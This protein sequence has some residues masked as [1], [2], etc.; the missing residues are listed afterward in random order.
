MGFNKWDTWF[1]NSFPYVFEEFYFFV[2][3]ILEEK[4]TIILLLK[5]LYLEVLVLLQVEEAL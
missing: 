3:A 1:H 2:L 5:Y 4:F